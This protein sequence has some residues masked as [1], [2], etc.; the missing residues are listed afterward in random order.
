M[1]PLKP[2]LTIAQR[3]ERNK[4]R[5]THGSSKYKVIPSTD[6]NPKPKQPSLRDLHRQD[7]KERKK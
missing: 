1:K 4:Q 5:K 2:E 6:Y 3:R 7:V